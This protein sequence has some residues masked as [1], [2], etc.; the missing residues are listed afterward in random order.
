MRICI[1]LVGEGRNEP[2]KGKKPVQGVLLIK[3]PWWAKEDKPALRPKE[4]HL[5]RTAQF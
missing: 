2:G 4:F 3:L 1:K 5:E